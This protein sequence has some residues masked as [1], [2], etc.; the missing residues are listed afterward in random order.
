MKL[1]T[2]HPQT[3]LPLFLML[4]P[5]LALLQI[6]CGTRGPHPQNSRDWE[7]L[8]PEEWVN[9]DRGD[10]YLIVQRL[11]PAW[12]SGRRTG[13]YGAA[14]QS[15]GEAQVQ[16]YVDGVPSSLGTQH[17]KMI[18]ALDLLE[19]RYLSPMDATTRFGTDHGAGAI[20]VTTRVGVETSAT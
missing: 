15:V 3:H 6:T 1:S 10:A 9:L 8:A 11:R 14:I 16:V 19:I 2:V 12:L 5:I 4:L 20:L 17:L 7:V 13:S 18:P